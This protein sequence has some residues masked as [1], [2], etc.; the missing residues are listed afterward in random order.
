MHKHCEP[1]E[2]MLIAF[3][4][5]HG[6][7]KLSL[8][9]STLKGT[10][11]PDSDIDLL[12]EFESDRVPGLLGMA[13]LEAELSTLFGGKTVD[14]RTPGDLSRYFRD[15]VVRTAETRYAA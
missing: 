11:R 14:L 5:A 9:G 15:D 2:K 7:R 6:I 3:C 12:V 4:R 8:F 1:D 13:E 10:A